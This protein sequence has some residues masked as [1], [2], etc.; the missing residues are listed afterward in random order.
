MALLTPNDL[1]DLAAAYLNSREPG[2]IRATRAVWRSMARATPESALREMWASGTIPA[3]TAEVWSGIYADYV[4]TA[5]VPRLEAAAREAAGRVRLGSVLLDPEA[6]SAAVQA[7]GASLVSEL[8][9]AQREAVTAILRH[10]STVAPFSQRQL[11]AVL[12]P[13]LGV[14]SRTSQRLLA[15]RAELE[16]AGTTPDK[17]EKIL[18]RTLNSAQRQRANTIART[19]LAAAYNSGIQS[20]IETGVSEGAFGTSN[21]LKEWRTQKDETTCKICAPLDKTRVSLND[22]FSS[23]SFSGPLPPAHPRCRC[24]I[25]Y[26]TA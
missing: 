15:M 11:A 25:L 14:H 12:K 4:N 22:S 5:V 1:A 6:V 17:V 26:R 18:T 8:T 19:E 21:M 3:A 7:R 13:A 9:S 24:V 20:A 16:A 10:H 23:G 2:L